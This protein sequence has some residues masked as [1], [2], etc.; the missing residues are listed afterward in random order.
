MSRDINDLISEFRDK[1]VALLA[2][3]RQAGIE[4]VP[5]FTLRTPEEQ[6]KLWR[7]SRS[8]AEIVAMISELRGHGANYLADVIE[9]V[10][11]QFGDPVTNAVPGN[12][13]HQWGEALDCFW[14]VDGKA[15]WS[16]HKK[17]D[18]KNGY[19]TYAGTASEAGLTAGGHW[20]SFKDWPHVQLRSA[21]SPKGT[22]LSWAEIDT[23]MR[24]KFGD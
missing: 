19:R 20:P 14:L 10:G 11:P 7:Q 2:S 9:S 22:G 17:I 15:E 16:I 12:S 18:G 6:A 5:Y 1:A 8:A 13:W 23:E 3:C 24:V 4:M 21:S